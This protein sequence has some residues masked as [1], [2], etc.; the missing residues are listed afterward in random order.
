[1]SVVFTDSSV[2]IK[3]YVRETG[4]QWV[5]ILFRDH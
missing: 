4:S 2:V 3:R 5:Q 1:M